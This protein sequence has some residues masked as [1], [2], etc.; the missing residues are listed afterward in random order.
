MGTV[1]MVRA[2]L[3]GMR[4]QGSG[5][6]INVSS[7]AGVMAVPYYFGPYIASK[8]AV[9]GYTEVLRGEIK[10]F[11]IRVAMV[12]LGYMKTEIGLSVDQPAMPFEAY[13][14]YRERAYDME[15]YALEKGRDP[16]IVAQVIEKIVRDPNPA[17]RNP[18]GEE[19][20]ITLRLMRPT[21]HRLSEMIYDWLFGQAEPWEPKREPLRRLLMDTHYSDTVQR[22]SLMVLMLLAPLLFIGWLLRRER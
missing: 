22:R 21:S 5:L 11:G 8:H 20:E 17:L 10:P 18:A 7:M 19:A 13:A 9:E 15:Q 4:E 12:E 2:V 1:A 6:I 14:P 3:P 16:E